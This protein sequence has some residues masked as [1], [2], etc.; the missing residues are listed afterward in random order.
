MTTL[1]D[2]MSV[3]HSLTH[4]LSALHGGLPLLQLLSRFMDSDRTRSMGQQVISYLLPS[5]RAL[6]LL[7]SLLLGFH[8]Q[9]VLTL[10]QW[11][12]S[13]GFPSAPQL[14]HIVSLCLLLQLRLLVLVT[15]ILT[16][17]S[18]PATLVPRQQ[19]ARDVL[20]GNI[21]E[22]SCGNDA[23]VEGHAR[24]WGGVLHSVVHTLIAV[25]AHELSLAAAEVEGVEVTLTRRALAP[26]A[27]GAGHVRHGHPVIDLVALVPEL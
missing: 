1:T 23:E 24:D 17:F 3:S 22:Q 14:H 25:E 2:N 10:Q 8:A 20:L 18:L 5:F 21:C 11:L 4:S 15:V 7:L 6:L 16:C 13:P 27:I 9:V 12:G 19:T 26:Q